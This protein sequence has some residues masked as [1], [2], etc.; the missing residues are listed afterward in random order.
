MGSDNKHDANNLKG[1][2]YLYIY[3]Y[4]G[5]AMACATSE[6][7][8]LFVLFIGT[9]ILIFAGVVA[10]IIL[11]HGEK[12][13]FTVKI[14]RHRYFRRLRSR[15]GG[16]RMKAKSL[17]FV[18]LLCQQ[19]CGGSA[20]LVGYQGSEDFRED[21]AQRPIEDNLVID[22][23]SFMTRPET[24]QE[25]LEE[26]HEES[27]SRADSGD[28]F[29]RSPG[30]GS[31]DM[32][33]DG[34]YQ[35][36]I[37][38]QLGLQPITLKLL[39]DDY[40]VMHRQVAAACGISIDD[41]VGIHH[42]SVAPRDLDDID[43]Q[44][45]IAQKS[46]EIFHGEGIVLTLSDVEFHVEGDELSPPKTRREVTRMLRQITRR[47]V[48]RSLALHEWCE[49][50]KKPC[51]VWKNNEIWALQDETIKTISHGD[52]IRCA[53][54]GSQEE[55]CLDEVHVEVD[56]MSLV[57]L[58]VGTQTTS[59]DS[60]ET[61]TMDVDVHCY[62][63]D[64]I[65]LEDVQPDIHHV[66]EA[67]EATWE[68]EGA[69]IAALH[70]VLEPPI[71][72]QRYGVA[73]YLLERYEDVR[74]KSMRDDVFGLAEIIVR[75][76]QLSGDSVSKIY[77]TWPRRRARRIQVLSQL[78]VDG[79]CD[80][81]S[82]FECRVYYN[83]IR[84]HEEDHTIR[85]FRD[86]DSVWVEIHMD[87]MSARAAFCTL[88]EMEAGE[89][90]RRFFSSRVIEQPDEE[91]TTGATESGSRGSRDRSRSR[92]AE[93]RGLSRIG[94][95]PGNVE[96]ATWGPTAWRDPLPTVNFYKGREP[97]ISK[98]DRL[99]PPGNTVEFFD[100]TE[101]PMEEEPSNVTE[102]DLTTGSGDEGTESHR[103][104]ETFRIK[105]PEDQQKILAVFRPWPERF[106][107]FDIR[108]DDSFTPV[109]LQFLSD[110]VIG[111]HEEIQEIH[112]YTDG[113]FDRRQDVS[114]YAFAVYGW[115][116]SSTDKHFFLGW[117]GGIVTTDSSDKTYIGATSHSAGDGEV[118]AISWALLWILQ[119]P[120]W[121]EY[122][123][124][125]D[126][127]VAGY[128]A[129][130]D[131]QY[132]DGNLHKQKMREVAQLV[133]SMRPGMVH[134]SHVKAHSNHPC[135]D[136]VDGFARQK[137]EQGQNTGVC[138]P[139]WRPL[140]LKESLQL[141][142]AWWTVRGLRNDP[143]I[144][145]LDGEHYSWVRS[146]LDVGLG[147]VR[148]F[149][150]QDKCHDTPTP[151]TLRLASYN[152][153]TL[154]DKPVAEG[155]R[156][157]DW[158]AALL[159]EQFAAKGFHVVGLQ[160]TRASESNIIRAPDYL[161]I[162]SSGDDGHHGC[163]LW[164][165]CG[166][167]VGESHGKPITI[168]G[169]HCTVL[170]SD[171]RILATSVRVAGSS[172]VFF[173]VHA[174]HDGTEETI[175]CA[176]WKQLEHLMERFRNVGP[177]VILG[178]LNARFG[179]QVPGRIGANTCPSS[180]K[181]GESCVELLEITDGWIPSTFED[182]HTGPSWSW[183][184][185]KGTKARLDYIV[186]ENN[187]MFQDCSSWTEFDIG[188]SLPVRDHEVVALEVALSLSRVSKPTRGQQYDWEAMNTPEG[189]RKVQQI[190]KDIPEPSWEV[191]VHTHWQRLQD[192]LHAGLAEAFPVRK[193]DTRD[194][195][196]SK[197]TWQALT[198]RKQAKMILNRCDE[199]LSDLNLRAA[200]RAWKDGT[201]LRMSSR[202]HTLDKAILVLCHLQGLVAFR[203]AA[204]VVRELVKADKASF[205]ES[206]VDR[207]EAAHGTDLYKELRPL[208]IGGRFRRNATAHPGFAVEGEQA[209]DHLHNEK[210]WLRYCAKLEAG[211]E[212]TTA[213]LLQRARRGATLRRQQM[214][215]TFRLE[216]APTLSMLEGAFR[217]VK[218]AKAG[219]LDGF[220]SDLCVAAPREMAQKFFPIMVKTLG[221]LEEPIQ[222]KGGL[223]I[224][225][226]K[227]GG[228][229]PADPSNHR[230]LLLSS[231]AGKAIRRVFRKQLLPAYEASAPD[232]FFSIR[233]G[234]NVA[235]ASHALRL[236]ASSANRGGDSVGILF[237]DVKAAYYRVLR[238]LVVEGRGQES[239]E[240][241][242]RYF[243]L[244]ASDFQH[245][246]AELH[247]NPEGKFSNLS[248]H[249]EL[250]LEELM[251]AT[252]LT[253]QHRTT[254]LETLAGSRPGDG[255]A[256]LIFGFAFK[257]IM[258][259]VFTR[260][261]EEF[262]FQEVDLIGPFDPTGDPPD[263]TLP[264]I[265]QVVW[266]DDLAVAY[267]CKGAMRLVEAMRR[268]ST[269][270]F[271]ECLR[272]GL[273]PNLKRGKTEILLMM[274]GEGSRAAK[275]QYFNGT[276]PKL[277]L[278]DLP[279]EF[280]NV[281]LVHTY[282]HLG[283]RI[284]IGLKMMPELKAR[285][286]QA[287]ATFRKY[288][289]QIFQ[290]ARISLRKRLFLFNSLVA[291]ILEFNAGTWSGLSKG[292]WAY[293]NKRIM[294]MY[295]SIARA[296][297]KEEELRLWSNHRI[298]AYLQVPSPEV[299]VNVARLRYMISLHRSAPKTL[300]HLIGADGVWLSH[301]QQSQYWM[302]SHLMGY[303]P[304]KSGHDWRPA[305]TLW[306]EQGGDTLKSWIRKAKLHAIL[307]HSKQVEWKEFH[308][309]FLNACLDAGWQHEFPWPSAE[310]FEQQEQVDACL[311][312]GM[313]FKNKTAWG[314]PRF[315]YSWT[316]QS[317]S[318]GH[319]EHQMRCLQ[320]GVQEH[321]SV[322]GASPLQSEVL[323]EVG[324][325]R[326]D[327]RRDLTRYWQQTGS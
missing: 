317:M 11:T 59:V 179:S 230:S 221:G 321:I 190:V 71:R 277:V 195:I 252:W 295:R 73:V 172:F 152:T 63:Q 108:I 316:L 232:T 133:E 177:A 310:D 91:P 140:F 135:N 154:R 197:G 237:L 256:D 7:F 100:I 211:V 138:T 163:E 300:W 308:F 58:H 275:A 284:H 12:G 94:G 203:N 222:M 271:E 200:V 60:T 103:Q 241:V 15:S 72:R 40:W 243:D 176:W 324:W 86:G 35:M 207:A 69:E 68:I 251:S 57:Q 123:L 110:C 236:F 178:D 139:D 89:R 294:G 38:F 74:F 148:P 245:L 231:H 318:K 225:A 65:M 166:L 285:C 156:G 306:L 27:R 311:A 204:K 115:S 21:D 269:V 278:E 107:T 283:T 84:W 266:A 22:D 143:G 134:F 259:R 314:G 233:T 150:V 96:D 80:A 25:R 31:R 53:V 102:I 76:H 129:S 323:P 127:T 209:R 206:V 254:I 30:G 208:R 136:M 186:L 117:S 67:L 240:R 267:R 216:D 118:S 55:S 159:R 149:E 167:K 301:L 250:L 45:V 281:S 229:N 90:N 155:Y 201:D 224:N 41:L 293:F 327:L 260:L 181:N 161:R 78:R 99:P 307:E 87:T 272:H 106:L 180:T 66:L 173:V 145:S 217:H 286:G 124:H 312:C 184:H 2:I 141:S 268:I 146:G 24:W 325:S 234:G 280:Q 16:V 46:N 313:V 95:A 210:L 262:Q 298:L 264:E 199:L 52:Y 122:F 276:D 131:W 309:V 8:L 109:A 64:L 88:E 305:W 142:W 215:T 205:V 165:H 33:G 126:S 174:P 19:H 114:S 119:S 170:F 105:P 249:Q 202:P 192:G 14:D 116:P 137:I 1:D 171:P 228:C 270:V 302:E 244:G 296:T 303:G 20:S 175:R 97:H 42:V 213:R 261:A 326:E 125:F 93:G 101:D 61:T 212:T 13:R 182:H 219:G 54:H 56:S 70:E 28:D 227:G 81:E 255:F 265:L 23:L 247:G 17:L 248:E 238:Q 144:P 194:G 164:I 75:G 36:A 223:V 273:V 220:K 18:F 79:I 98:F 3:T 151:I 188:S 26:T 304:D 132:D 9:D 279:E 239:L 246:M 6:R 37:I 291:S 111:W 290:N 147:E 198:R 112:I 113:S 34:Y 47:G 82:T 162:I 274:K 92:G 320:Q 189:K 50:P 258:R 77:A 288:R 289:R 226:Y 130:G 29:D 214:Q 235:H 292:E 128:T 48:L 51:I 4:K 5:L 121:C 83:N 39:W 160:E 158:K 297:I 315:S 287:G 49:D 120:Y 85:Q 218:K 299:I 253:G 282:R 196:F 319:G 187:G 62:G 168:Q 169:G 43:L 32:A 263:C 191:D 183:T 242:M 257:R 153:M 10:W 104:Q 322:V 193:K 185:P 157:E 44:A